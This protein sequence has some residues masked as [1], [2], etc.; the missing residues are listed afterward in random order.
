MTD[1]HI[2]LAQNMKTTAGCRFIAHKRLLALDAS[3]TRITALTSAY[4]IVLTA[5]PYFLSLPD[6]VEDH[7]NLA[8]L[9]L[10]IIILVASLVQY[11]SNNAATAEQFHRSALEINEVRR[12]LEA[13]NP[14][15]NTLSLATFGERYGAILQKYSINQDD[16]D[17]FIYQLERPEEFSWLS[18]PKKKKDVD[19]MQRSMFWSRNWATISISSITVIWLLLIF[20]YA[21]P[22]QQ[23]NFI[24]AGCPLFQPQ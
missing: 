15:G 18:D 8:T 6:R 20:A 17:Y 23:D 21:L 13:Q 2:E 10:A 9:A 4:V 3:W 11:S 1:K 12:E 14:A 7:V 19:R 5:A 24:P 22:N 16:I